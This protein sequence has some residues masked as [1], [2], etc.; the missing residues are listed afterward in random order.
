MKQQSTGKTARRLDITVII[1]ILVVAA[2]LRS[3]VSY[4]T[5]F[6]DEAINLYKGWEMLQGRETYLVNYHMGWPV[7]SAIPLGFIGSLGGL[8]AARAANAVFGVAACLFTLMTARMLYGKIAG[9]V[10]GGIVA[11]YGPA[12]FVSTVVTY[13]SLSILLVSIALYLWGRALTDGGDGFFI[14][15]STAM[16]LAVLTKY[17]AVMVAFASVGTALAIAVVSIATSK[18]AGRSRRRLGRDLLRKLLLTALPFL[19]LILY[20]WLQKDHLASLVQTQ[21][22]TK[23]SA[24]PNSIYEILARFVNYLWLPLLLAAAAVFIRNKRAPGLGLLLVG[25]SMMPYHLFN[26]DETTLF[27]HTCYML[28]GLAPLAAGSIVRGVQA[29]TSSRLP[30]LRRSLVSLVFGATVI[31]YLGLVGQYQLVGFRS[32]WPDTTELI[33]YLRTQIDQGDTILM[34]GGVVAGYYL[35]AEG[36]PGHIPDQIVDTW[37]Y[38]DARGSGKPA[39]RRAITSQS[40]DFIILSGVYTEAFN[41]EL[42]QLMEGRYQKIASFSTTVLGEEEEI[43][44]FR[45]IRESGALLAPHHP[46]PLKPRQATTVASPWT[47]G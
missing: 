24:Q 19:F 43:E 21:V 4:R 2:L 1:L 14:L 16:T 35:V 30:E 37:S 25:L 3:N 27:K 38:H 23:Q 12:I 11:L 39:Y 28:L 47:I 7:L 31:G 15:G 46:S 22:L 40:F 9:Y 26:R 8:Q 45:P 20:A 29:L 17:A 10:A 42:R 32:Y 5:A 6:V 41:R 13:D 36:T 34:E 18:P 44:I 33:Q